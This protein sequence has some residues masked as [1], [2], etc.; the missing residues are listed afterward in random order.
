MRENQIPGDLLPQLPGCPPADLVTCASRQHHTSPAPSILHEAGP[1]ET[2][3]VGATTEPPRGAVRPPATPRV[4]DTNL[5]LP[6]C[7]HGQRRP[8]ET[9]PLSRHRIAD[10][11]DQRLSH[12]LQLDPGVLIMIVDDLCRPGPNCAAAREPLHWHVNSAAVSEPDISRPDHGAQP[13]DRVLPTSHRNL[14]GWDD[15][16]TVGQQCWDDIVARTTRAHHR[17]TLRVLLTGRPLSG[18][19]GAVC[20]VPTALSCHNDVCRN[21]LGNL[22]QGARVLLGLFL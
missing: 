13:V 21:I 14:V 5:G 6:R 8:C 9:L 20:G 1:V 17:A 2:D 16:L 12:P 15:V 22:A 4:R 10:A 7:Y 11:V 3:R 19:V 18:R